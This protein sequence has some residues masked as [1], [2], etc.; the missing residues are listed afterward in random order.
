MST[1]NFRHSTKSKQDWSVGQTVKVGFLALVV[2]GKT[3]YG[4]TLS[5]QAGDKNYT[6]EPY[7]GLTRVYPEFVGA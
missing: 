4:Y 7:L 1:N 3:G 6:F 2:T 5:N